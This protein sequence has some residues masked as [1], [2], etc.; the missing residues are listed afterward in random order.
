M[1]RAEELGLGAVEDMD[2]LQG[3]RPRTGWAAAGSIL[4][5]IA[6]SSC[7]ILPL[8]LFSLCAGGAWIAH[9]PALAPYHPIILAATS[10]LLG[11]GFSAVHRKPQPSCRRPEARR[12]GAR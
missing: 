8:V 9:L 1:A 5:A 7:C 2:Q 6:A 12:G 3:H 4:G 10:G 11:Y